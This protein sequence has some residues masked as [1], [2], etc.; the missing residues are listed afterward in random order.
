MSLIVAGALCL[1]VV[2]QETISAQPVPEWARALERLKFYGD[3]RLRYERDFELDDQPDRDRTR[4]RGRIGLNYQVSD[5]LLVGARLVTGDRNDPNSSHATLGGGFDDLEINLD[6]AFVT[7]RPDWSADSYITAG[8]FQNPFYHNPVYAELTWDND[9][10]PEGAVTGHSEYDLAGLEELGFT[11]GYYDL[12]DE[13]DTSDVNMVVGEL[14]G[15]FEA[16]PQSI[17]T[18]AT[19]YIYYS[20]PTPGTSDLLLERNRGNAVVDTTGN[21]MPDQFASDFGIW[22]TVLGVTYSGLGAPIAFGAEYIKNTRAEVDDDSGYAVGAAW[23]SAARQDDWRVYYQWQV[24]EQDAVFS[25][26]S[27]DDF[28]LTTN[29]RSHLFGVNYQFT[30]K[31]GLHLWALVSARDQAFNTPT[32]D[33]DNNQWRVRLDLNVKL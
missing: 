28:I 17:A 1:V 11:V 30:D 6:Q 31:I 13:R 12:V 23:G 3:F 9:V 19:S 22:H 7:Y 27:Q 24:V 21:G 33:S 5:Q 8:K 26:I 32:T 2:P 15:S 10:Q 29:H 14:K 4:I 18:L 20:D 16:G 25:P